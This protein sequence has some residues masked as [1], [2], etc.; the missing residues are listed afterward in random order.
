MEKKLLITSF[1]LKTSE[2][3]K[4]LNNLTYDQRLLNFEII[5]SQPVLLDEIVLIVQFNTVLDAI[6]FGVCYEK[7]R[8]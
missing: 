3:S 6:Y 5:D 2:L 1:M 8:E 7:S 4:F